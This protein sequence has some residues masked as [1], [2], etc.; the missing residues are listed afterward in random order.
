MKTL[1][2]CDVNILTSVDLTIALRDFPESEKQLRNMAL[3]MLLDLQAEEEEALPHI[4][5]EQGYEAITC[6]LLLFALEC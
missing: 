1:T 3:D 6:F 5:I 4:P 2:S